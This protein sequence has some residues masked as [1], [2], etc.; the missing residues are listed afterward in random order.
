[1][2]DVLTRSPALT[3]PFEGVIGVEGMLTGD[4]RL[5]EESSLGWAQF[6]LPLRWASADFGGHDGAVIVGRIDRVERRDNG[7]IYAWGELDLGSREGREVMRLMRGQFLSGVSMDL[8]SVETEEADVTMAAEDGSKKTATALVTSDAR[9]RAAT[10]VAIPAFDEARL[11]LIASI[12]TDPTLRYAVGH[13]AFSLAFASPEDEKAAAT[14]ARAAAFQ[15]V[16][17]AKAAAVTNRRALAVKAARFAPRARAVQGFAS[18]LKEIAGHEVVLAPQR[19]RSSAFA[20]GDLQWRAPKGTP[21]AGRWIDMPGVAISWLFDDADSVGATVAPRVK[22]HLERGAADLDAAIESKD[23]TAA[24]DAAAALRED[25]EHYVST[26]DVTESDNISQILDAVDSMAEFPNDDDEMID[27]GDLE[28]ADFEQPAVEPTVPED[29]GVVPDGAPKPTRQ[30]SGSAQALDGDLSDVA[31]GDLIA[32]ARYL[33]L[34]GGSGAEIDAINAELESRGLSANG[35]ALPA[36]PATD[37]VTEGLQEMNPLASPEEAEQ[38]GFEAAESGVPSSQN[39]FDI[40]TPKEA[41]LAEAWLAGRA[42][43]EGDDEIDLTEGRIDENQRD[44]MA[45]DN[46]NLRDMIKPLIDDGTLEW[47][48][49]NDGA[50]W[51]LVDA[52]GGLWLTVEQEGV[53]EGDALLEAEDAEMFPDTA[54]NAEVDYDNPENWGDSSGLPGLKTNG[55]DVYDPELKRILTEDELDAREAAQTSAADAPASDQAWGDYTRV[56]SADDF[57]TEAENINGEPL[58][59]EFKT[60]V[61]RIIERMFD[62]DKA[63]VRDFLAASNQAQGLD[64]NGDPLPAEDEP[65]KL[66]GKFPEQDEDGLNIPEP[67]AATS[68]EDLGLGDFDDVV[69]QLGADGISYDDD[70]RSVLGMD[71]AE[72]AGLI[73]SLGYDAAVAD[74]KTRLASG[75]DPDAASSDGAPA[76]AEP[77][78]DA[79]PAGYYRGA[80]PLSGEIMD[81]A[82][83]NAYLQEDDM[84]EYLPDNLK[85]KVDYIE[86]SITDDG[87]NL[88]IQLQLNAPL[89]PEETAELESWIGG[90]NSDGLGENFEQQDWSSEY[91]YRF[92]DGSR[93]DGPEPESIE[94]PDFDPDAP[95]SASNREYIEETPERILRRE[96]NGEMVSMPWT[97]KVTPDGK[98]LLSDPPARGD[99]DDDDYSVKAARKAV[100]AAFATTRAGR[101]GKFTPSKKAEFATAVVPP[102]PVTPPK[103]AAAKS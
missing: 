69:G 8:D 63:T 7:D 23:V 59:P 96:G 38:A 86:W 73:D 89:T 83:A 1:M 103:T 45:F 14:Y 28:G 50:T 15:A 95:A 60:E 79:I 36:A 71:E 65:I 66:T 27:T 2:S 75:S 18:K 17:A 46:P 13:G 90:Q 42:R 40:N 88:E 101:V 39:P 72:V 97:V 93:A 77:A 21:I 80:G 12:S 67:A 9:I 51:E 52:D 82:G 49:I 62:G 44:E 30:V 11:S 61:K 19:L 68:L 58:T 41:D 34:K 57:F 55:V 56:L 31:G 91:E 100:G 85:A 25:F 37:P 92:S 102:F 10:L 16:K 54:A 3:A 99:Y 29:G 35:S 81:V 74:L 4:G 24:K 64:N 87:A 84:T 5:I 70:L 26:G 98:V 48:E 94:N 6:P 33:A 22:R 78:A 32:R 53:L 20:I 43:W 47:E 76:D